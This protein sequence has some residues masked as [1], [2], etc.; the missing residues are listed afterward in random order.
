MIAQYRKIFHYFLGKQGIKYYPD[1]N[2]LETIV[3]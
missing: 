2:F 1:K 3:K